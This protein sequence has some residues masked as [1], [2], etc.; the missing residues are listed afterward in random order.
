MSEPDRPRPPPPPRTDP[1]LHRRGAV[2]PDGRRLVRRGLRPADRTEPA[3]GARRD[4]GR[5]AR[6]SSGWPRWGIRRPARRNSCASSPKPLSALELRRW[7]G[8]PEHQRFSAP[9]RLA[10]VGLAGPARRCRAWSHRC[11][12]AAASP[13]AR[14]PPLRSA[15]TTISARDPTGR[16]P[17]PGRSRGPLGRPPLHVLLRD[18]RLAVHVRG[19]Q[20]SR[21][22]P[23]AVL[24][25]PR[26][27][28]RRHD[29]AGLVL[30]GGPRREGRRPPTPMG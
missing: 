22:R 8:R 26:G 14:R 17:R 5:R 4:P 10:R 21:G 2:L 23:R 28:R 27:A 11:C 3:R 7:Q 29:G 30:R 16:L 24:R 18:E 12:C 20:R 9:G 6:T 25:R 13:A 15:T 19:R 1:P